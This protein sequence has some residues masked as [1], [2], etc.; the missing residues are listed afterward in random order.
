MLEKIYPE[1]YIDIEEEN[2]KNFLIELSKM[3]KNE[4]KD[5]N[6]LIKEI[7]KMKKADMRYVKNN[8]KNTS[9]TFYEGKVRA[10]DAALKLIEE[11]DV[12]TELDSKK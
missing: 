2:V 4:K 7:I 5:L 11:L 3:K 6:Y 9:R 10:F 8:K 12:V 1:S